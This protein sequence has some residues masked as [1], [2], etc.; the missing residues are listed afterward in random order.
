MGTRAIIRKNGRLLIA[1]HWDGYPKGLGKSLLDMRDNSV[2][3][4]LKAGVE[5]HINSA[6]RSILKEANDVMIKKLKPGGKW[7]SGYGWI[8]TQG[9]GW[10]VTNIKGY[11]DFAEWDYDVREDGIYTHPR[12][13]GGE[14]YPSRYVR[15]TEDNLE[16]LEKAGTEGKW[17][18]LLVKGI[19]KVKPHIRNVGGRRVAVRPHL[20]RVK[21]RVLKAMPQM[22]GYTK[23]KEQDAEM[24]AML[25]GQRMSASGK[26]YTERRN[27]RSDRRGTRL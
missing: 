3:S 20:K 1:T 10:F 18:S 19:A 2:E 24:D 4:I 14:Y 15:L 22:G 8:E 5:S 9:K 16:K 25:P 7:E 26:V 6:D 13:F 12:G 23:D 21:R 27:N 17:E 11:G